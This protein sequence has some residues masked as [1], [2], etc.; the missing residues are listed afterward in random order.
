MPDT[1]PTDPLASAHC[2]SCGYPLR[3]VPSDRCPECGRP[4]DRADRSTVNFGR[5]MGRLGR[6]ALAG[7]SAWTVGV[8][9]LGAGLVAATF[10]WPVEAVRP[11]WA[12]L[13]YY[14]RVWDWRNRRPGPTWVD[15]AYTVG[16]ALVGVAIVAMV[17]RLL[18]RSLAVWRYRP[19]VWQRGAVWRRV[20]VVMIAA[21]VA[22]GAVL[23]GWP[24]RVGQRWA[25]DADYYPRGTAL[26]SV[27]MTKTA[28]APAPFRPAVRAP[29]YGTTMMGGGPL[30]MAVR[31]ASGT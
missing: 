15:G 13:R 5:P 4:F 6:R 17:L 31:S 26:T 16:L 11:S 12:D 3:G 20:G 14:G 28:I 22:V 24:Y 21:V 29:G 27:E 18:A 7:M 25:A 10:R 1:V 23:Y 30:P 8:A 2:W 9:V 19:P